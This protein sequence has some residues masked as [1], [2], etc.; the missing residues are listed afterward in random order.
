MMQSTAVNCQH[1]NLHVTPK[2]IKAY[3]QFNDEKNKNFK[4]QSKSEDFLGGGGL[5]CSLNSEL[6][7]C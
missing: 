2:N 4:F 5:Y 1:G 6:Q 7:A 3:K